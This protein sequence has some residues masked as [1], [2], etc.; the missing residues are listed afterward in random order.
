VAGSSRIGPTRRTCQTRHSTPSSRTVTLDACG[1]CV[2]RHG[3]AGAPQLSRH[4]CSGCRGTDRERRTHAQVPTFIR[5]RSRGSGVTAEP[6]WKSPAGLFLH[7][8]SAVAPAVRACGIHCVQTIA[9]VWLH[10]RRGDLAGDHDCCRRPARARPRT[11][12][13]RAALP[14]SPTSV[15]E[16][17]S[18]V[19]LASRTTRATA[20]HPSPGTQRKARIRS[21]SFP[22]WH[23]NPRGVA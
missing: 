22:A 4:A 7:A 20:P 2:V 13:R 10:P 17:P 16:A 21:R 5:R 15:S 12:Q 1:A 11:G 14:V 23:S 9:R 3:C 19:A 8:R 6:C 18:H